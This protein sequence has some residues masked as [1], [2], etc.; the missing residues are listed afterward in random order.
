MSIKHLSLKASVSALALLAVGGVLVVFLL[1]WLP[2]RELQVNGPLYRAVLDDKDLVADIL[3]PALSPGD[4]N[5]AVLLL[6]QE[7]D[8]G[9]QRALLARVAAGREAFEKVARRWIEGEKDPALR[10]ALA[11]SAERSRAFFAAADAVAVAVGHG[12]AGTTLSSV[13]RAEQLFEQVRATNDEVLAL[14]SA[15][16]QAREAAA[17]AQARATLWL[18][19]ALVAG[20]ALALAA[21]AG[22]LARTVRRAVE[23][24]Q[25]ASRGLRQAVEEGRLDA[26][27]DATAV[28]PDLRGVIEGMNETM[29]AVA[30]PI[31]VTTDYVTRIAAGEVPPVLTEAYAGDFARIQASLNTLIRVVTER[32]RDLDA[33]VAAALEGRL[34]Y[35]AD[36]SRYAGGNARLM[37]DLN[38]VLDAFLAPLQVAATCVDRLS[39]GEV[40]EPITAEFR[41]DFDLLKRNLNTC[42]ASIRSLVADARALSAA[43]VEGR[44]DVRADP[45]RHG[46]EYRAIITGVND[47]LDAIVTPFRVIAA[48]CERISHGD[49]PPRRTGAVK[50]EIVAMQASLNRCIDALSA[51]VEDVNGVGEAAVAGRLGAR[52]DLARH[53]G[54]FRHALEGV[55]GTLDAVVAPVAEATAALERLAAKDLRARVEGRFVGDHAKLKDAVNSTAEALHE[56]LAQVSA[57]VAQVS[58]AAGQIAASSHAVAS[59]ASQQASSLEETTAAVERVTAMTQSSTEHAAQASTLALAAR[60]AATEGAGAVE[61]LQEA[62]GK[63]KH[64]AEAT[65]AIIHDVSEIAFQTNLLA[66]NAAV[67]AARAGEAGRGFAV[68]AEEVRSLALRAKEAAGKTEDLIRQSVGQAAQGEVAGG[69]VAAKLGEIVTGVSKAAD[70]VGE[71]ATAS[72]AQVAAIDQVNRAVAEM[73]RVTQQN[74]A[75]AEESSSAASELSGQAEELAAMVATFR[76]EGGATRGA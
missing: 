62:M 46:G 55:N 12:D 26:R 68:V 58:G 19:L 20:L 16:E 75:S 15:R 30:R 36:P 59:G 64:S 13:E 44:L 47:T 10:Q 4:A 53:E 73:E 67:E 24:V 31:A 52:I 54:A 65:R 71:I 63:I 3:P 57:S 28:H 18:L 39:R 34:S 38:R 60:A 27:A 42:L 22:H 33:L 76:V 14:V 51:M 50:G 25:A 43:A 23:G 11:A 56:A 45:T 5:I 1:T 66:L 9:R 29:D 37:A 48:Y 32:S 41:G 35:R 72:S 21:V 61:R 40:P 6:A 74:A 2:M 69:Q 17:A 7:S 70:I 49:L 8:V